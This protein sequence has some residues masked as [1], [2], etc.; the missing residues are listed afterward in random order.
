MYSFFWSC[1]HVV[2]AL[3]RSC[4]ISAGRQTQD[5]RLSRKP[6]GQSLCARFTVKQATS[7]N[8]CWHIL[9]ALVWHVLLFARRFLVVSR[10]G[11]IIFWHHALCTRY[12]LKIRKC[13]TTRSRPTRVPRFSFFFCRLFRGYRQSYRRAAVQSAVCA[14][15]VFISKVGPYNPPSAP[16][17]ISDLPFRSV[18]GCCCCCCLLVRTFVLNPW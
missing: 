3:V 9:E 16:L 18:S 13:S 6:A 4:S 14:C 15:S 8:A 17:F 1:S 11:A 2:R 7:I 5:P 10:P 12:I